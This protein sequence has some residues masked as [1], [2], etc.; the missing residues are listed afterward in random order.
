MGVHHRAKLSRR[1]KG[2]FRIC[3]LHGEDMLSNLPGRIARALGV[4]SRSWANISAARDR[5]R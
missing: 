2:G 5:S 4:I 1:G 3:R